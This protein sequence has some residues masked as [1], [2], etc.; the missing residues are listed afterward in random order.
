MRPIR[1]LR[2]SVTLLGVGAAG[3]ALVI[4]A[5]HVLSTPQ[6][7]E[8]TLPGEGRI[9]R[10]H[11]GDV[12]YN[13]LGAADAPPLVLLHDF[14]PGAS[15]FQ[16]RYVFPR[17]AQR[18]RTYAPDWLG[19]GMSEHPPVAYTGEFYATMLSGFLRDTVGQPATIVA[20]GRAANLAVRV[21]S[22]A[23][24]LVE[25]L[26]LVA[27]EAS[28]GLGLEP[29]FSQS[30][31]RTAQRASLGLVPYAL[32]SLK[33]ALRVLMSTRSARLHDEGEALDHL[34]ASAHQFGGQHALL[35]LLTGE[36]DLP[37]QNA[38]ALL[39]P[40]V[41][42]ISGDR[43]LRHPAQEME[44]L[45]VLNPHADLDVIEGAG[46]AVFE[47]QPAAFVEAITSWLESARERQSLTT[48]ELLP[49]ADSDLE[50]EE[51]A[52]GD[53]SGEVVLVLEGDGDE[54]SEYA[55][56]EAERAPTAEAE[57]G[58]EDSVLETPAT[59]AEMNEAPP[60][61][62]EHALPTEAAESA[63]E[64]GEQAP[65]GV[66]A[67][68]DAADAAR[69][70]QSGEPRRIP[71]TNEA[72]PAADDAPAAGAG[73]TP[74]GPT[75]TGLA[76][77]RSQG[78]NASSASNAA[79]RNSRDSSAHVGP[80]APARSGGGRGATAQHREGGKGEGTARRTSRKRG[81]RD[82]R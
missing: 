35:A 27:P 17:L 65:T 13:L 30:L 48:E 26:V 38:L 14:Y 51:R 10:E 1:W 36:L 44:D 70:S 29:T 54:A 52:E 72:A 28:V 39:E 46:E 57:L 71:V 67:S 68:E 79:R 21:A 56:D 3:G 12:F 34:Y 61:Q 4:T 5:R 32:L 18:Y 7:L 53:I 43:D 25:R 20:Q 45:A 24:E 81:H 77:T 58:T 63:A 69:E 40:P 47:D 19:F 73:D 64:A 62:M 2:R 15:N 49:L 6:P 11:G 41:L 9:D 82:D 33:P 60:Q 66:D 50:L 78:G 31:V 75:A 59:S 16:W 74:S 42:L 76:G 80:K 23:P 22:D 8:S 55:E 37:I